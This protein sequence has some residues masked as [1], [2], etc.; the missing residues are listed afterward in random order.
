M[1]KKRSIFGILGELFKKA[2]T[3]PSPERPWPPPDGAI[4]PEDD[5]LERLTDAAFS[6]AANVSV[7]KVATGDNPDLFW[8]NFVELHLGVP[9]I[10]VIIDPLN[11]GA[12]QPMG[13]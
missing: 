12:D 1:I 10:S 13:R 2:T 8:E 4:L 11:P 7:V 9:S 6:V 3:R 5:K